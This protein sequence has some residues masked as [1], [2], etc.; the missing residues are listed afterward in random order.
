MDSYCRFPDPKE[1]GTTG[2]K[3]GFV[4]RVPDSSPGVLDDDGGAPHIWF[5]VRDT[6]TLYRVCHTVS[7]TIVVAP[8]YPRVSQQGGGD[9][10]N[11]YGTGECFPGS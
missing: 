4:R 6:R 7:V 5:S 8:V 9:V 3:C 10:D 11:R 2:S 1:V